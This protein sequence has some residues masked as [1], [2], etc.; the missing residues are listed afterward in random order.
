MNTFSGTPFDTGLAYGNKFKEKILYN[1]KELLYSEH[2]QNDLFSSGFSVWLEQQEKNILNNW[3]W[4]LNEMEGVAK[5]I[6]VPYKDILM[7]NLRAWQYEYYGKSNISG[8]C[9][10]LAITLETGNVANAGILDDPVEYYCGPVKIVPDNGY[11]FLSF[12][13]T[14]T[15]WA[16]RGM[17]SKGLCVG[18]SSQILPGL[19]KPEN[20][21]N[22]DIA[23]R[24]IL[25]TM[26]T[27]K[28]VKE[29]CREFPFIMNL[30]CTDSSNMILCAH[31]TA[32]GLF[33]QSTNDYAVMTN[34]V[35]DDEL[36]YLLSCKGTVEFPEE[37]TSRLRRGN[38]LKFARKR[39]GNVNA[40]EIRDY[41]SNRNDENRG[42]VCNKYSIYITYCC[43]HEEPGTIYVM[44][45]QSS[46]CNS[47]FCRYEI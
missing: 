39:S 34:H 27:V 11:G 14:G 20:M 4:L 22:Q 35:T 42:T 33:E 8:A 24:V 5:S 46:D 12:P 47:G 15:V 30:V 16:N 13:L 29:F 37:P 31:Q 38:L 45:P 7:L 40:T 36:R 6:E 43:P 1:I 23:I 17:N 41:I 3:P 21:I 9:S 26:A 18:I 32:V 10:S 19:E 44:E 2:M 28:E 25:Q